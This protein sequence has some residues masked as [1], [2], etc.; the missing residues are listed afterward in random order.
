MTPQ[1]SS[2]K[3]V[4]Y[5]VRLKYFGKQSAF[6]AA[7]GISTA[8]SSLWGT[9]K[10][11]PTEG[12]LRRVARALQAV[13]ASP[14]EIAELMAAWNREKPIETWDTIISSSPGDLPL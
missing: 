13:G 8:E 2:F 5:F 3:D 7:V 4:I 10:R 1:T 11:R 14:V 6:A 9:G 12:S